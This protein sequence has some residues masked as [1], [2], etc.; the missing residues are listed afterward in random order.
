MLGRG[1]AYSIVATLLEK[2]HTVI[3]S[4]GRFSR[5]FISLSCVVGERQGYEG[6]PPRMA[7]IVFHSVLILFSVERVL[8]VVTKNSD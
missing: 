8:A 3:S 6:F 4:M 1:M 2:N 7:F 5:R